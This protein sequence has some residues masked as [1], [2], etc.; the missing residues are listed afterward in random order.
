LGEERK[1]TGERFRG[2]RCFDPLLRLPARENRASSKQPLPTAIDE[3][4]RKNCD[5]K[6]LLEP[7][8]VDVRV[9]DN[10][11]STTLRTDDM[12]KGRRGG[13][14]FGEGAPQHLEPGTRLQ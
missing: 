5:G 8:G 7:R 12:K 13:K 4:K 9:G 10:S 11:L 2:G 1:G 14:V 3:I 6:R